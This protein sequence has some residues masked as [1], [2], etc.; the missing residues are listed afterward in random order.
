LAE[1]LVYPSKQVAERYKAYE[2][3]LNEGTVLTGFITEQND[4][5]VT[6]ADREQVHRIARSRIR[7]ISPQATSLMPEHLLNAL[8]SE[9]LRDL[10]A[11]LDENPSGKGAAR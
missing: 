10:V 3:T 2:V 6:L 4:S 1:S 11:F 5:E 7:A 8:S 9:E